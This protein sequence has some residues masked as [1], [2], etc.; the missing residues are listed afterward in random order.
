MSLEEG[1]PLTPV[2][3]VLGVHSGEVD[4]DVQQSVRRDPPD[5]ALVVFELLQR[6][7]FEPELVSP[8]VTHDVVAVVEEFN[9]GDYDVT[10]CRETPGDHAPP[11]GQ[12]QHRVGDEDREQDVPDQVLFA[13]EAE[14]IPSETWNQ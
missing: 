7:Q 10:D 5:L 11:Q 8:G 6:G 13:T 12:R 2:R 1:F 4:S 14:A 9:G 3:Q